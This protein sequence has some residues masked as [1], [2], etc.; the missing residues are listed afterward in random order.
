MSV[1]GV[2]EILGITSILRDKQ[3]KHKVKFPCKLCK[4]DHLTYLCPRMDEASKFIAQ[5]PAVLTN[6]LPHNQ[7]M[8]SK[9][10]DQCS[11]DDPLETSGRGC[12]NMVRAVKVVTCAKDY[13]SSQPSPGKEPDLPGTPL[14]IEKPADK[15]EAAPRIPKGVLKRSGHNPNS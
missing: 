10:Q 14:R 2:C 3:N 6:P 15:L 11:D 5:G 12:I 4:D 8:N 9:S 13:T 7:N 1:Q